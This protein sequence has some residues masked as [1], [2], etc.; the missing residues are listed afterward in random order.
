MKIYIYI[1]TLTPIYVYIL[2]KKYIIL[3]NNITFNMLVSSFILYIFSQE[4]PSFSVQKYL[5]YLLNIFR[6]IY[7]IFI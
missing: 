4:K 5:S 6:Y 2:Y 7:I 3:I 1:H